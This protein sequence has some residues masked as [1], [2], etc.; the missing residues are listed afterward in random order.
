MGIGGVFFR[1]PFLPAKG[2]FLY[3]SAGGNVDILGLLVRFS[4]LKIPSDGVDLN[5]YCIYKPSSGFS[6]PSI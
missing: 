5:I 4:M 1:C 6:I 2:A 3:F